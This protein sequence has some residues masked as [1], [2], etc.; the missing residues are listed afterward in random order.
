MRID[1]ITA[2]P[3]LFDSVF[4][5]GVV[6]R[7]IRRGD[8]LIQVHDLHD[9]ASDRHR[10]VDDKP[11]GGGAGMVFK[12]EPL[13]RAVLAVRRTDRR[14]RPWVVY[15]SPQ[16]RILNQTVAAS[17]ARRKWLVL[18]AGRYEGIDERAMRDV[19]E[20]LSIGDYV[21][22]GGEFAA[23]VVTDV[24]GRYAKGVVKERDSLCNE[25]FIGK[26]LDHPHYTRPAVYRR[27]RVP[28]VLLSG[29]HRRIREYRLKESIRATLRKRPELLRT[30]HLT[31]SEKRLLD[32]IRKE[33]Y[34]HG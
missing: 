4:Q 8:L 16:G 14:R 34:R 32:E 19:D 31:V 26:F 12:P 13:H 22:T 1:I 18:I 7:G 17:L 25:S 23:M 21:L 24:V 6:G 5:R 3:D 30:A 28:D 20:E 11:Y 29:D 2:L 15:L 33:E 9:Y 27:M 10:T